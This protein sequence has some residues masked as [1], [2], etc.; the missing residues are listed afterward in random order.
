MLPLTGTTSPAHMKEDLAVYDAK[1]LSDDDL[2][3]IEAVSS[4]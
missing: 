1:P 4:T 2:K 3:R